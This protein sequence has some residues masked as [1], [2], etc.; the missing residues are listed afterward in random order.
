MSEWQLIETAPKDGTWIIGAE[1]HGEDY[2]YADIYCCRW[3][4]CYQSAEEYGGDP[5]LY[6]RECWDNGKDNTELPTHWMP[7]PEPPK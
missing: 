6:I 4:N 3:M 5:D 1:F 7:L 2:R